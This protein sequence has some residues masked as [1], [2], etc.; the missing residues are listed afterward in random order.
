MGERERLDEGCLH[1]WGA[2]GLL[3]TAW[4]ERSADAFT[5]DLESSSVRAA[6]DGEPVMLET[7]IDVRS[8][9][10]ALRVLLPH[11]L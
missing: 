9:A 3:P 6:I 11:P 8:E 4:E 7:P 5:I 2:E 10:R 1:L